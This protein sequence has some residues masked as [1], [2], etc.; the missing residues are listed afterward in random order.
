M[1]LIFATQFT[2]I[3]AIVPA[4]GAIVTAVFAIPAFREQS[5]EVSIPHSRIRHSAS[6]IRHPVSGI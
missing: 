6:G 1:S 5:P 4:G 3:A 2:A